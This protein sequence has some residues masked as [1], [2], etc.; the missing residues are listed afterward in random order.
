ML[1]VT[2]IPANELNPKPHKP[3][4]YGAPQRDAI[5]SIVDGLVDDLCQRLNA[6][7]KMLDS[8]EQQAL[9]SAAAAKGSLGNH[10]AVCVRL[11]DEVNRTQTAVEEI[12][13]QM[14][15]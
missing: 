8:I 15:D 7:R 10:V 5:G 1:N 12:R 3:P 4:G 11:N 6:V 2:A 14:E 9:E 13:K